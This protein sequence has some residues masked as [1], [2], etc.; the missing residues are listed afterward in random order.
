M[1]RMEGALHH[2]GELISDH[3]LGLWKTC[4]CPNRHNFSISLVSAVCCWAVSEICNFSCGFHISSLFQLSSV[5]W[6]DDAGHLQSQSSPLAQ[7]TVWATLCVSKSRFLEEKDRDRTRLLSSG[8]AAMHSPCL[9]L[10]RNIMT[11]TPLG[12]MV[13]ICASG[14]PDVLWRAFTPC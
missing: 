11:W 6:L 7:G 10:R 4:V 14:C 2:L 9:F 13:L 12:L 1:S 3:K 8:R 5:F